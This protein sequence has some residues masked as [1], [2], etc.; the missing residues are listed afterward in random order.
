ME[1]CIGKTNERC[2]IPSLRALL[3]MSLFFSAC[4]NSDG[5]LHHS[6][7][8]RGQTEVQSNLDAKEITNW[9][10]VQTTLSGPKELS[11]IQF[12]NETRMGHKSGWIALRNEG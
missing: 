2:L 7:S 12:L 9:R 10:V 6:S 5:S 1:W 4:I 3:L 8:Q 11:T